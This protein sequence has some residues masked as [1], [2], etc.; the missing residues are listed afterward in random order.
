[1]FSL[2][3]PQTPCPQLSYTQFCSWV[4]PP[5]QFWPKF[6]A[7]GGLNP[8]ILTRRMQ[9]VCPSTVLQQVGFKVTGTPLSATST[10]M[11]SLNSLEAIIPSGGTEGGIAPSCVFWVISG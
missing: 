11:G 7:I 6:I 3:L 2:F 9:S 1:M 5:L 10:L 8:G 4:K